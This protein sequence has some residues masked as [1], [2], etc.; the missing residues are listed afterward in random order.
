MRFSNHA[1]E[2]QCPKIR[3]KDQEELRRRQKEGAGAEGRAQERDPAVTAGRALP[4]GAQ[5]GFGKM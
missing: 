4:Q 5:S 1:R 2:R 3:G